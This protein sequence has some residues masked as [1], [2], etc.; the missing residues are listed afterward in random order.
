MPVPTLTTPR[1]T[2]RAYQ[3]DDVAA[4]FRWATS[5]DFGRYTPTPRP[6]AWVN[7]EQFVA[8][9]MVREP[10][11]HPTFVIALD[12][13]YPIGDVSLNLDLSQLRAEIGYGIG[14][15]W[16]GRGYTAEAASAVIAWG[17]DAFGLAKIE[18]RTDSRN[19]GSWRVMEKLGMTR[20]GLLRGHR[21]FYGERADELRYGLLREEFALGSGLPG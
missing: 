4:V 17:F 12:G 19:A 14:S 10:E 3:R 5:P 2:L 20:E 8:D 15:Q 21:F 11:I 7:A 6:Y 16:W 1:L 9:Q 18:A 13:D